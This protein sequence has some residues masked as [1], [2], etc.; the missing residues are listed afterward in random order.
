VNLIQLYYFQKLAE[1]QHFTKAAETLFISQPTLSYSIKCLEKELNTPLFEKRGRNI[2]LTQYGQTFLEYVNRSI[3]ELE[4]G[5]EIVKNYGS[6]TYGVID[7]AFIYT[8]GHQ[9]I[10]N[11]VSSFSSIEGNGQITFDL[12]QNTSKEV[13]N[14]LRDG[15]CD[16]A[17]SSYYTR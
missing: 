2:V 14:F 11:L 4:A 6:P 8:M 13:L 15:K 5:T 1:L 9:Y 10:S 7:L 12:E 3:S 16:I 17:F